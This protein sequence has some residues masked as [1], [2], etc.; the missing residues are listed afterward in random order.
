MDA[1]LILS[2]LGMAITIFS[3]FATFVWGYSKLHSEQKANKDV[4]NEHSQALKE[5][6]EKDLR[7]EQLLRDE[8]SSIT[9][10]IHKLH[11]EM[12]SRLPDKGKE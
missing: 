1:S 7:T 12:L 2:L 4:L 5:L 3:I 11:I 9:A 6:R 8:V 10:S